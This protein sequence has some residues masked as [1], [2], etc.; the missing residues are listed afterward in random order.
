MEGNRVYNLSDILHLDSKYIPNFLAH[1]GMSRIGTDTVDKSRIIKAMAKRTRE[2]WTDL[3]LKPTIVTSYQFFDEILDIT[4]YGS[5]R[6]GKLRNRLT[7]LGIMPANDQF[8]L[9]TQ[10]INLLLSDPVNYPIREASDIDLYLGLS[11]TSPITVSRLSD[12]PEAFM[13]T[14]DTGLDGVYNQIEARG[15]LDQYNLVFL[16]IPG[17]LIPIADVY[18]APVGIDDIDRVV[19]TIEEIRALPPIIMDTRIASTKLKRSADDILEI[20]DGMRNDLIMDP[21]T[22]GRMVFIAKIESRQFVTVQGDE[23]ILGME[24]FV[25]SIRGNKYVASYPY[26]MGIG[27]SGFRREIPNA[28]QGE[29]VMYV[30]PLSRLGVTRHSAFKVADTVNPIHTNKQLVELNK[31]FS[32][33]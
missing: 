26:K 30:Y 23:T 7:T 24:I 31:Y 20:A 5:A 29:M 22:G 27:P 2:R 25:D 6:R 13:G 32:F 11:E 3:I 12:L 33:D 28:N 1:L 18:D 4:N 14:K 19:D 21:R 15:E 10:T 8:T 9:M 16:E 17:K